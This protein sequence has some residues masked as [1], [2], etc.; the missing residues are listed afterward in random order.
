[1]VKFNDNDRKILSLDYITRIEYDPFVLG[2]KDGDRYIKFY[3]L[4][5]TSF[6][7]E[8]SNLDKYYKDKEYLDKN[9][10]INI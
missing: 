6:I 9:L 3:F 5:G 8:Y 10:T 2:G 4:G 7:L 1:M